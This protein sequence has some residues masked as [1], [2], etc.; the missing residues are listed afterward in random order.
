[1]TQGERDVVLRRYADGLLGTRS[2]IETIG[3]RD[4][5]DLVIAMAQ[6]D[7]DFPKPPSTP[8]HEAQV[9]RARALLQPLLRHGH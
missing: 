1:M 5:A 4:Y 9:A 2:A 8:A 6:A 7:L 3:A